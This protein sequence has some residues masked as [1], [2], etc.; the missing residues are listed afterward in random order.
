MSP[1]SSQPNIFSLTA[2][3][4]ASA[5]GVYFRAV[6]SASGAVDSFSVATGPFDVQ[7]MVPATVT[8]TGSGSNFIKGSGFGSVNSRIQA[9]L[10]S[11]SFHVT[12]KLS[13]SNR[14]VKELG[15]LIDGELKTSVSDG[16]ASPNCWNHRLENN[17]AVS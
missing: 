12:A 10:G 4:L 5:T 3:N 2:N 7:A 16:S 9:N 11:L 6:A 8:I 15:L 17:Y 13:D 1:D 14:S